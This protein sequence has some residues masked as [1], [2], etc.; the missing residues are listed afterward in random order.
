VSTES[1]LTA[2][3]LHLSSTHMSPH[4]HLAIDTKRRY[5]VY[6][7]KAWR[8]LLLLALMTNDMLQSA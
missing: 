7:F 6:N 1:L 5:K 4:V 2:R 3:T 8:L